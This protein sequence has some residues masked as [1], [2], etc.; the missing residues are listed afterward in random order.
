MFEQPLRL[1]VRQGYLA[2]PL[3]VDA[4]VARYDFSQLAPGT[5]GLYREEELNRVVAGHR[6]TPGIQNSWHSKILSLLEGQRGA[7]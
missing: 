5:G 7:Q 2:S 1:M 3:K 6:A 4:A